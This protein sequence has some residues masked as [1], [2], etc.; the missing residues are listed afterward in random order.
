MKLCVKIGCV[1][2]FICVGSVDFEHSQY[3]Q[4]G[5]NWERMFSIFIICRSKNI[6]I[7]VSIRIVYQPPDDDKP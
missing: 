4:I 2:F 7:S 3:F 6:S 5:I 1:F